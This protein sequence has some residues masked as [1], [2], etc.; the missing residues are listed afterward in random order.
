VTL[1]DGI[2]YLAKGYSTM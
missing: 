1:A 2:A